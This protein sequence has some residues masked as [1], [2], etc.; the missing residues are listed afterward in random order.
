MVLGVQQIDD[1]L[2][3]CLSPK[4]EYNGS[5]GLLGKLCKGNIYEKRACAD[6]IL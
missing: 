5:P 1:Q 2:T 4:R 3:M 6:S